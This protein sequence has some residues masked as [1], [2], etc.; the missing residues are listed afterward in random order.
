M[1]RIK[2]Y[3]PTQPNNNNNCMPQESNASD[4]SILETPE[5]TTTSVTGNDLPRVNLSQPS[6][7][8]QNNKKNVTV[9]AGDSIV[10]NVIGSRMGARDR[11]Y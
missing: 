1:L 6:A 3:S 4:Q 8:G 10:K 5:Y 9:I 11:S 7:A 2:R